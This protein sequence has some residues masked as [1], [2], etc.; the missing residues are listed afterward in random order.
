MTKDQ[1]LKKAIE[2]AVKNGMVIR[3]RGFDF[4]MDMK[5]RQLADYFIKEQLYYPIIFSH[6]FAKAFWGEK[7]YWYDTKCS[8][9]GIGIHMSDDTHHLECDRVKSERGYKFH[10]KKMVL[11]EQP[12]KYLERFL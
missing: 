2:K 11:E 4:I 8:C 5:R 10:L 6:S 3:Q 9:G 12:L 7:D 1:I